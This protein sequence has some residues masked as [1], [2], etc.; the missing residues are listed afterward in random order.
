MWSFLRDHRH[1][2][3]MD[4]LSGGGLDLLL[5]G[6]ARIEREIKKPDTDGHEASLCFWRGLC[7]NRKP[8]LHLG[9]LM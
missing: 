8:V 1:S 6:E 3:A 2:M 5:E 4:F 7:K 9:R